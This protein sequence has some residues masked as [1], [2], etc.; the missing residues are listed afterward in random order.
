MGPLKSK[1]RRN[2][3]PGQRLRA[4]IDAEKPLQMPGVINA[5]AAMLAERSGFKGVYLSGAAVA[6]AS[7]GVPDAGLTTLEDV[8]VDIRRISGATSLPL[9]VDADTGWANPEKAVREMIAAG[10]AGLHIED[11][12]E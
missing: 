10:A 5:Y 8:L 1:A 7:Y 9:L 12:V 11:Q 6:N 4:A 2:S 3:K